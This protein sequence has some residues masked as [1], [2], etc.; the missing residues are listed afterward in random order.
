MLSIC[1]CDDVVYGLYKSAGR[2]ASAS[3]YGH[4]MY[5]N[6]I[7]FF[8]SNKTSCGETIFCVLGT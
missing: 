4:D 1:S 8:S 3:K 5:D 7:E 2:I 6:G